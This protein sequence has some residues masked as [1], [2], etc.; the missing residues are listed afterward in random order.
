[1]ESVQGSDICPN[2]FPVMFI[3][4]RLLLLHPPPGCLHA[5]LLFGAGTPF[6]QQM[7]GDVSPIMLPSRWYLGSG[8][9]LHRCPIRDRR[10]CCAAIPAAG[11]VWLASATAIAWPAGPLCC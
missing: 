8:I 4:D 7:V 6:V 11:M 9:G 1:M 10:F 2:R 3:H 5:A